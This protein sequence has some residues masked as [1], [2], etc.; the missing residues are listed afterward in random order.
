MEMRGEINLSQ[1]YYLHRYHVFISEK[2]STRSPPVVS[3]QV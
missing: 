3:L 2:L 1:K